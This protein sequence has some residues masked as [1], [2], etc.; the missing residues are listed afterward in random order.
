MTVELYN[1]KDEVEIDWNA[2][3]YYDE[4]SPSCLRWKIDRLGGKYESVVLV[5]AGDVAGTKAH[6]KNGVP[7]W[8]KVSLNSNGYRVHRIV[9]MLNNPILEGIVDHVDGNP[10]NNKL[11]NLRVVSNAVNSRNRKIDSRNTTGVQGVH[12][13]TTNNISYYVAHYR[14]NGKEF[15]KRFS[16]SNLGGDVALQMAIEWRK[17]NMERLNALGYGYTGRHVHGE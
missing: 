4:T 16:V 9:L 10:F 2:Y 6:R 7:M 3:F 1:A 12:F 11:K 5:R 13:E 8:W 17:D 14:E 15:K